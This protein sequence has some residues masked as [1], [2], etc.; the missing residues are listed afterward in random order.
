LYPVYLKSGD[1]GIN[2]ENRFRGKFSRCLSNEMSCAKWMN[3]KECESRLPE[4][5]I[6]IVKY[7]YEHAKRQS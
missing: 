2:N 6:N 4:S 3:V 7:V 5:K 1:V